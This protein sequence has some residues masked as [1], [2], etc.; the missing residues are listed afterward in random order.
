M[1]NNL[2][3]LAPAGQASLPDTLEYTGEFSPE[4]VLFVP[5][6]HW[7]GKMGYLKQRRIRIYRGMRCFYEDLDCLGITEKDDL[8]RYV[9]AQNRPSWLP[10][11]NEHDFDGLGRSPQHFFPDWRKKFQALPVMPELAGPGLPL[12]VLHNKYNN[13]WNQG[14]INYFGTATL[15]AIFAA[16]KASFRIVY[17][18]HGIGTPAKGYSSDATDN[19]LLAD[20]EVLDRHPEVRCF[21]DLYA[22][23]AGAGGTQDLNTFK[24]VLYSRCYRFI[25]TQGGGAHQIAQFSGSVMAILHRR[26]SEAQWAYAHG[27]YRFMATIPPIAVVCRNDEQLLDVLPLFSNTAVVNNQILLDSNYRR[28]LELYVPHGHKATV[29][30]N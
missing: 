2:A 6:C 10:I 9:P 22:K 16:L 13:E 3:E 17:I 20:R 18:R 14:P 24:N 28:L 19:R 15:D 12:L 21:D 23:Y 5:F 25:S 1:Q 7:L 30:Q 11:K 27:Y 29:T 8:R 26:G 4:L